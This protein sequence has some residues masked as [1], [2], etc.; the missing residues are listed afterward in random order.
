M[1]RFLCFFA[2]IL[3]VANGYATGG[4]AGGQ[5]GSGGG[6]GGGSVIAGRAYQIQPAVSVQTVSAIGGGG[7]ASGG[8]GGSSGGYGGSSGGYGGSSGGYGGSSVDIRSL[9]AALGGEIS[10]QQALRLVQSLP[11]AGR[12]LVDITGLKANSGNSGYGAGNGGNLAY[13]VKS[14][15]GSSKSA[16]APAYS[17][18]APVVYNALPAAPAASAG[19]GSSAPAAAEISSAAAAGSYISDGSD[20]AALA[21]GY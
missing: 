13:V 8:Y 17:A 2:A 12:P 3:V 9:L 21:A 4:G 15:G 18:P 19:Y 14:S 20:S 16:P 6:G 11:S 5:Y 1:N 10:A 7:A